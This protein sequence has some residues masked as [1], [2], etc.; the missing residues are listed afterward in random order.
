MKGRSFNRKPADFQLELN[1]KDSLGYWYPLCV[2]IHCPSVMILLNTSVNVSIK[3]TV[4]YSI[5]SRRKMTLY[6][7]REDENP[8]KETSGGLRNGISTA[9]R[10]FTDKWLKIFSP[11]KPISTS[12]WF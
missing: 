11:F 12:R 8:S 1:K 3:F 4:K 2:F 5:H 9:P 6:L 7:S 10:L